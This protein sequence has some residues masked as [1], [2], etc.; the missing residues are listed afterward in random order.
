MLRLTPAG[1]RSGGL[2][3]KLFYGERRAKFPKKARKVIKSGEAMRARWK[4]QRLG[5]PLEA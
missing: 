3:L 5:N 1:Q 4:C 2:V